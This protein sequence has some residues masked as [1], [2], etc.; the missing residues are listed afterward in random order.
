MDSLLAWWSKV[1]LTSRLRHS[2]EE[3]RVFPE[4]I[5]TVAVGSFV[6]VDRR[7]VPDYLPYLGIPQRIVAFKPQKFLSG[8]T[9]RRDRAHCARILSQR[10][11]YDGRNPERRSDS[12]GG[13]DA[14][15]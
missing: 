9:R 4:N 6:S 15:R 13:V 2:K 5:V 3:N 8:Q 7:V 12:S 1:P 11:Q 10:V 14:G